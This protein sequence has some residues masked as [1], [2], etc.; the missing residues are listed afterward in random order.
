MMLEHK[1]YG[2]SGKQYDFQVH[3]NSA[4]RPYWGGVYM[5]CTKTISGWHIQSIGECDDLAGQAMSIQGENTY[6][7]LFLCSQPLARKR[8]VRDICKA[9]NDNAGHN[10]LKQAPL[11]QVA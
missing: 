1:W 4:A 6:V 11:Q 8:A 7:H 5:V 9:W 10:S 3:N 2:Q